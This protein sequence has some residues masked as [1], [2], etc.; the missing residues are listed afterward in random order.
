MVCLCQTTDV[1]FSPV[2]EREMPPSIAFRDRGAEAEQQQPQVKYCSTPFFLHQQKHSPL[3]FLFHFPPILQHQTSK[4]EGKGGKTLWNP[5]ASSHIPTGVSHPSIRLQLFCFPLNP[6]THQG[7]DAE[8]KRQFNSTC[9]LLN[10]V[11]H[12]HL[13]LCTDSDKSAQNPSLQPPTGEQ[14]HH[15]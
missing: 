11:P 15:H 2:L 6:I 5:F 4:E 9:S 13:P 12:T 14:R 8:H 1:I 3:K 10:G 7:E